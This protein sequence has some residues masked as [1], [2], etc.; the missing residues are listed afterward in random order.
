MIV[1]KDLLVVLE[2]LCSGFGS[3]LCGHW[4]WLGSLVVARVYITVS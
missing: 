1:K 2:Q 4:E 3:R